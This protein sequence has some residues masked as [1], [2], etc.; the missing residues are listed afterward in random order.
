MDELTNAYGIQFIGRDD[1]TYC[2]TKFANCT[3]I[4]I[5]YCATEVP[6]VYHYG[7]MI[8]QPK[9]VNVA[10]IKSYVLEQTAQFIYSSRPMSEYDGF[11]SS[12][13]STYN[14]AYLDDA[15]AQLTQVGYIK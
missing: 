5:Q 14:Q 1:M 10:D 2:M 6:M 3:D 8:E 7:S 13:Y 4:I 12:L 9:G 11:L 15:T